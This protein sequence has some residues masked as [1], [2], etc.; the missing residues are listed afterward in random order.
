MRKGPLLYLQVYNYIRDAIL[1]KRYQP[2]D[3]ILTEQELMTKFEVSRMTT[4]RAL[5]MLVSEGWVVR[6]AG[7]GTFVN[8]R[9]PDEQGAVFSAGDAR[10][11]DSEEQSRKVSSIGFVVPFLDGTFGRILLAQLEKLASQRDMSVTI[12]SSYGDQ[13]REQEAILRLVET[14]VDGLVVLPVN[15]EF[16]NEAILR[17][18]VEKFPVVLVDKSLPG[19]SIPAVVSDNY[20][21]AKALTTHLLQLGHKKL[22]FCAPPLGGTTSLMDRYQGFEDAVK[23]QGGIVE[24]DHVLTCN[25]VASGPR[26]LDESQ[27]DEIREFLIVHP[28]VTAVLAT[29][30]SLAEHVLAAAVDASRKIPQALA[31]TCFDGGYTQHALW[32]FTRAVQNEREMANRAFE[33]LE[34]LWAGTDPPAAEPVSVPCD[35]HVGES[36]VARRDQVSPEQ[37][38]R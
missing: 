5:Q 26:G 20:G 22:A 7:I 38:V 27:V 8:D 31:I 12:S 15:R 9:L 10:A 28:E 1:A 6:R 34:Q 23:E 11:I 36:T 30:D 24:S 2:G 37:L 18:N 3:A 16:Y 29:D 35:I 13:A 25:L 33:I 14:G 17:L 21:A 19:I 32:N 4:N